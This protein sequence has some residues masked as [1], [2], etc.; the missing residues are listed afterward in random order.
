MGEPQPFRTVKRHIAMVVL[1]LGSRFVLRA[2]SAFVIFTEDSYNKRT[3]LSI[4]LIYLIQLGST[5]FSLLQRE[6][7]LSMFKEQNISHFAHCHFC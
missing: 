5:N 6:T 7:T 2:D 3:K 4:I 1:A